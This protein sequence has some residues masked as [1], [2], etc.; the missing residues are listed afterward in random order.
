[1]SYSTNCATFLKRNVGVLGPRFADLAHRVGGRVRPPYSQAIRV[2]GNHA[3]FPN[4]SFKTARD[5]TPAGNFAS[6][7][8]MTGI[9]SR[10]G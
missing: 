8:S 9:P 5:S 10:T 3:L 2:N 6:S 1:M 7:T 4:R